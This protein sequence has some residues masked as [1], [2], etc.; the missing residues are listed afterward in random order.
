[1]DGAERYWLARILAVPLVVAMLVL[2]VLA[3]ILVY[4]VCAVFGAWELFV[5]LAKP[6]EARS[7]PPLRGPLR[8]FFKRFKYG[9]DQRQNRSQG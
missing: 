1:M 5:N 4:V 6:V 9:A 2:A 7:S 3:A 8:I